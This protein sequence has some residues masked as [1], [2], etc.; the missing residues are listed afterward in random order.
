MR[1]RDREWEGMRVLTVYFWN[2]VWNFLSGLMSNRWTKWNRVL[3]TQFLGLQTEFKELSFY[4]Q[5]PSSLNSVCKPW[6]R[7][8]RARFLRLQTKFNELDLQAQKPSSLN[9]ISGLRGHALPPQLLANQ[10]NRVQY[11][12]FYNIKIDSTELELL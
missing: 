7:V 9:S 10:V 4:A 11:T 1:E 3:W 2:S 12:R 6:N 5:K 8:Q